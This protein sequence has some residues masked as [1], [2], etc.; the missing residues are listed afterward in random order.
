VRIKEDDISKTTFRTIYGHYGFAV[1]SFGLSNA[2]IVFMCPINGV[3]K[4]YMDKF[5]IVLLDDIPIYSKSEEEHEQHLRKALQFSGEKKL[6][7]KLSKCIFYQKK[8]HYSG[9]IISTD[10]ILVDVEKIEAIR[11]WPTLRNV[12]DFRSFMGLA[13]YY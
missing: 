12:T 1:M 8:I 2:P 11:G 10:G 3:F 5:V 9:H 7:T 4:E 13:D 6:Y